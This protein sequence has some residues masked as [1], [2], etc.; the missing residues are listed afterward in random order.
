LSHHAAT[1]TTQKHFK[2]TEQESTHFIELMRAK[3]AGRDPCDIINMDQT[4]IPFSFHSNKMLETKCMR[5]IHVCASTTDT[6][7]VTLAVTLG[8]SG[9][10]FPPMLIFKDAPNSRIATKEFLT[11]PMG[12][13]Y[14]CQPKAWADEQAM[15]N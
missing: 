15:N 10:M 13:H 8:V 7:Q 11:Y 4:P 12:G 1:H 5:S 6:K 2:E 9:S 14:L 3:I